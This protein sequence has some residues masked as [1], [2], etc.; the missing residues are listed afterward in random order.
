MRAKEFIQ[1]QMREDKVVNISIVV[2]SDD[3]AP[4][5]TTQEPTNDQTQ[6]TQP[7]NINIEPTIIEPEVQDNM[8]DEENGDPDV[9]K[10]IPPLQQEI[11]LTKSDAGK[12][13]EVIDQLTQDE[14]EA[15]ERNTPLVYR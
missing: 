6:T 5:V 8:P 9:D 13:S 3:D 14:D 4:V 7:N 15:D 12:D 2:P 1:R 11:E 10:M